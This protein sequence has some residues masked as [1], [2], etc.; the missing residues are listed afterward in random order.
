[1]TVL[2]NN[3]LHKVAMQQLC[4]TW[5]VLREGNE[6]RKGHFTHYD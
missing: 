6:K 1:M 5:R 3:M 2:E 4:A